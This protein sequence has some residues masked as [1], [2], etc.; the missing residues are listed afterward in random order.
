MEILEDLGLFKVQLEL[1]LVLVVAV[2]HLQV[3]IMQ[4]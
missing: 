2:A 4:M 3:E 1:K